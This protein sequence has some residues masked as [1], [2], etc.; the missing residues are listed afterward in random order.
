MAQK[1]SFCFTNPDYCL[2]WRVYCIPSIF[3]LVACKSMQYWHLF[4]KS[5]VKK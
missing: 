1:K 3:I 2:I 5:I 4:K